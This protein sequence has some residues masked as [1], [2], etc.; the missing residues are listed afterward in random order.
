MKAVV[1]IPS[2]LDR[3]RSSVTLSEATGLCR[4]KR[5]AASQRFFAALGMT[6][7]LL[8]CFVWHGQPA[9]AQVGVAVADSPT[10]PFKDALGEPLIR[11]G[12]DGTIQPVQMSFAAKQ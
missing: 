9:R 2:Y 8:C 4:L 5:G 10:G 12:E 7:F 11:R 1:A 3:P 6:G